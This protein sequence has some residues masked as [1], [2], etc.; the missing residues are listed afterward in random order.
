MGEVRLDGE[1]NGRMSFQARADYQIMPSDGC[2]EK[3]I[4]T[5]AQFGYGRHGLEGY[6]GNVGLTRWS[7]A[8]PLTTTSTA[9]AASTVQRGLVSHLLCY[10]SPK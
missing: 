8:R 4:T 10:G 3:T 2:G 1:K 7:A 6:L 5:A 9:V